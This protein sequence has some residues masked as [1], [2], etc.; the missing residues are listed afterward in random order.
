MSVVEGLVWAS[1]VW[2]VFLA[3]AITDVPDLLDRAATRMRQQHL[4]HWARHGHTPPPHNIAPKHRRHA[5]R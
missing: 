4:P 1:T 3:F 5:R 2:A